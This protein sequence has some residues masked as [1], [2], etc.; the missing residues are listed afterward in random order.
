MS[1]AEDP[2]LAGRAGGGA[3][4]ALC[5]A[6]G[7]RGATEVCP[8]PAKGMR[9]GAAHWPFRQACS[10]PHL[11]AV[12]FGASADG[13]RVALSVAPGV[14]VSVN[15]RPAGDRALAVGDVVRVAGT[16]LVVVRAGPRPHGSGRPLLGDSGV[17]QGVRRSVELVATRPH[18]VVITGETGTGKEVVARA[19]HELSGR[20]GPFIAVNCST[21]SETLLAS[22]LFGHVRGAF[23]GAV[24]EHPGLFRAAKGGTLLLDELAEIPLSLQ[25]H[26]LRVLETWEVRPVGGVRDIPVDVRLLATTNRPLMALVQ[27]GRFRAD[28]YARLAQWTIP[29][30]PLRERREDIPVLASQLL[31]RCDGVDRTLDVDLAEQLLLHD[32][33][34][35]VRGLLNV[36]AVAVIACPA[37]GPL[38]LAPEVV[39]ALASTRSLEMTTARRP[40]PPAEPPPPPAPGA[41]AE[42]RDRA[43]LEELMNQHHGQVASAARAVGVNRTTLYRYLWAAG[44]EPTAFRR[45]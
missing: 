33:P 35:N 1:G 9:F 21:F 8:V 19:I 29:L 14:R 27:E 13:D 16:L 7:G 26:L 45:T 25:A 18:T 28:L 17:M 10:D 6:S 31:H 22:D 20:K 11:P 15:G 43:A 23:T 3:G 24:A 36:L 38:C 37:D 4:L 40:D 44:L 34:L 39:T 5:F 2:R 42:L 41:P 32:W 30:P 12:A